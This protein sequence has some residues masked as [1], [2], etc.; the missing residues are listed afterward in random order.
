MLDQHVDFF[1]QTLR[2]QIC[3]ASVVM[4]ILN[5]IFFSTFHRYLHKRCK[6]WFYDTVLLIFCCICCKLD[7]TKGELAKK[8]TELAA[9]KT[10]L[11]TF[12]KHQSDLQ[13]HITVLHSSNKSKENHIQNLQQEVSYS[14][15]MLMLPGLVRLIMQTVLYAGMNRK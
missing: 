11:E 12:E 13:E 15:V 8:D 4:D 14:I 6:L 9:V 2:M 10:K 5:I 1:E 7:S 3:D